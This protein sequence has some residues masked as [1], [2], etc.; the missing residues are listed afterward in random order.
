MSIETQVFV[1]G[2]L[3]I[4]AHVAGA[5]VWAILQ[6]GLPKADRSD[7][8]RARRGKQTAFDVERILSRPR[9][10]RRARLRPTVQRQA[11]LTL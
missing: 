3:L 8:R 5:A 2:G 9:F 11:W 4:L 1:W 10:D 7:R 6:V